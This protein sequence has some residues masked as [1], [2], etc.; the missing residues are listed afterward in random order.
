MKAVNVLQERQEAFSTP[1]WLIAKVTVWPMIS[2]T[3]LFASGL[4]TIVTMLLQYFG[5][6]VIIQIGVYGGSVTA[7][8]KRVASKSSYEHFNSGALYLSLWLLRV[9]VIIAAI[10]AVALLQNLGV[11]TWFIFGNASNMELW[12]LSTLM[13]ITTAGDMSALL[14]AASEALVTV[15]GRDSEWLEKRYKVNHRRVSVREIDQ[16]DDSDVDTR[17]DLL[18]RVIDFLR[19]SKKAELNMFSDDD[20]AWQSDEDVVKQLRFAEADDDVQILSVRHATRR[21]T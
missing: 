21:L 17:A 13:A 10:C 15:T 11:L 12:A 5:A 14:S 16:V 8:V 3:N 7:A 18:Q 9:L 20:E 19:D 2:M 6:Q 4:Q 1:V